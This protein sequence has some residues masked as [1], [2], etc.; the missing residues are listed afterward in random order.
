MK[1]EVGREERGEMIGR[2]RG[3]CTEVER[4]GDIRVNTGCTITQTIYINF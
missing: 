3:K 1:G 4:E 2:E